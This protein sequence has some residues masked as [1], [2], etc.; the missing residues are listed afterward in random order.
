MQTCLGRILIY[1]KR[2]T[3]MVAF[4]TT[5]FGYTRHDLPEDRIAELRPQ[6]PVQPFSCIPPP[7]VRKSAKSA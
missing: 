1:T 5:L 6:P 4:Y 2:I 3:D 7:A